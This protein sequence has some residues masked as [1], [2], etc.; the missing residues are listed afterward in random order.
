MRRSTA[1]KDSVLVSVTSGMGGGAG[2]SAA[3]VVA[4]I[5]KE[6]DYLTVL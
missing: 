1:L 5:S 6:A 4:H 2:S 3:P